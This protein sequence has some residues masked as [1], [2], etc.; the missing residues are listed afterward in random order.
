MSINI[1]KINQHDAMWLFDLIQQCVSE[2][3][4]SISMDHFQAL[5]LYKS[6]ID[7]RPMQIYKSAKELYTVLPDI[8]VAEYDEVPV[9]FLAT[10]YQ[11]ERDEIEFHMLAVLKNHRRKGCARVLLEHALTGSAARTR[12]YGR[13]Y[14]KSTSAIE[15]LKSLG[16][17]V[18]PSSMEND[19]IELEFVGSR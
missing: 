2:G 4:F 16:F 7:R 18:V 8:T 12:I 1:R 9:A 6:A 5:S 15:L 3:H 14:K 10:F 17:S 19:P 13:C 11:K